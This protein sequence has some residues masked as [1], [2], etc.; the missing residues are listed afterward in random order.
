MKVLKFGGTSV[1]S[2]EAIRTVAG[3]LKSQEGQAVVVFSALSGATDIL[4]RALQFASEGNREYCS[5]I[6]EIE[7]RHLDVS[8][9]LLDRDR[10]NDFKHKMAGHLDGRSPFPSGRNTGG[11]LQAG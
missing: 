4:T 2:V 7:R 8:S 5:V 6:E 3:I 9:G 11:C 1:G 10:N